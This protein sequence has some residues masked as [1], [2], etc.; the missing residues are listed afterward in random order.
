MEIYSLST[1]L[2]T[3]TLHYCITLNATIRS[4]INLLGRKYFM[5]STDIEVLTVPEAA[6]ILRIRRN[7]AY[8]LAANGE[9]PAVRLGRR[10]VV[11][12]AALEKWLENPPTLFR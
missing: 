6:K 10:L 12:R 11:P 3:L 1:E 8:R 5:A 7:L 2:S 4:V 9:I